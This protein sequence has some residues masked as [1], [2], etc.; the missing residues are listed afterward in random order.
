VVLSQKLQKRRGGATSKVEFTSARGGG[1]L[2]PAT[3][4]STS[5]DPAESLAPTTPP[6][7]AAKAAPAPA[8]DDGADTGGSIAVPVLAPGVLAA[9]SNMPIP[10]GQGMTRPEQLDGKEITY[11]REALAAKVQGVMLVRCTITKQGKVENCRILKPVPHME[12]AV[13][14]A[15]QSRIY[16]PILYKG[17]P[18]AVDYVFNIKLQLP[19]H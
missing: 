11:T 9:A 5:L 15:L 19:R 14:E 17:Q 3:A 18:V 13:V 12:T 7:S 1:R 4:M 16:K 6:P 2:E 10:Y 8:A